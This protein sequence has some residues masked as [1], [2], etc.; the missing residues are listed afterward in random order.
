MTQLD[1]ES[2]SSQEPAGQDGGAHRRVTPAPRRRRRPLAIIA[3]V[4]VAAPVAALLVANQGASASRAQQQPAAAPQSELSLWSADTKP[5]TAADVD[6][7]AV[8]V[9]TM[10]RAT[11]AGSVTGVRFY[12]HAQNK[13]PHTGNLWDNR[14]Q[15]LAS[16][17]FTGETASGW[18]TARLDKAVALQAGRW[19]T[20]SYH[21]PAGRYADDPDYFKTRPLSNGVL[22]A[23]AGVYAYGGTSVYPTKT[24]QFSS[25]FADVL[26]APGPA[27]GPIPTI[28]PTMAP[29]TKPAPSPTKPAPTSTKPAPTTTAPTTTAPAPAPPSNGRFPDASNTGVPDGTTL[30]RYN[31][32]CELK[33]GT[34]LNAVDASACDSLL[35]RGAGVVIRNSM[36]PVVDATNGGSVVI[37]D[38][39][40]KGGNWSEGALWGDHITATRVEV[41]G[42]Q[43]S[44]HCGSNCTVTDSWLHGQ[45]EDPRQSFHNNAFI[46]NGGSNIVLRHNTLHCTAALN[47]NNGGCTAD[48]SLFGDF[49]P[50][51]NVVVDGNLFKANAVSI[52]YCAYGGYQPS[53]KYPVATGI[54]YTNNVFERGTNGKCGVFGP[55]TSFQ[56]GASGNVWAGNVWDNGGAVTA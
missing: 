30:A 50:V 24:W 55:V 44:V 26:F 45:Y 14:G 38:S 18:Q 22:Q 31:G 52:S 39:T 3:A 37:T 32:P 1:D 51:S 7:S 17:A 29:T 36:V 42:G 8:E 6:K 12:K 47:S 20:V 43:H 35:I 15:L 56:K 46:T 4:A 33:A 5:R 11:V 41:T 34:V 54:V 25:Y 13:G 16:V 9:G 49:G 28:A 53:K 48:V 23:R 10:F 21:A 19:Y 40:V 27:K 2:R